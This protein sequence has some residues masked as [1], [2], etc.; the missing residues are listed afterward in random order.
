[1]LECGTTIKPFAHAQ[2]KLF[3]KRERSNKVEACFD[4][5]TVLQIALWKLR[6]PQ[7]SESGIGK[8]RCELTPDT[9]SFVVVVRHSL[10]HNL[11]TFNNNKI[12]VSPNPTPRNF[13]LSFFSLFAVALS[14]LLS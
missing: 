11:N 10:K 4:F 13:E 8:G 14:A 5:R 9:T 1:M 7:N 2:A 6:L 3:G 12:S